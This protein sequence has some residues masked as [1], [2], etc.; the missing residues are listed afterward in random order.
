MSE[1]FLLPRVESCHRGFTIVLTTSKLLSQQV[2]V[3]AAKPAEACLWNV[4][5]NLIWNLIWDLK[6][7][8][9]KIWWN[10]GG[11]L[12]YLPGKHETFRVEFR[13]K[14]RRKFRK[15]RFKFRDFFGN[16]V[17][18]KGG[19]K[20][21]EMAAQAVTP[22]GVIS[23]CGWGGRALSWKQH[24]EVAILLERTT[25]HTLIF[26]SLPFWNSLQFYFAGN[27]LFFDCFS[28]ILQGF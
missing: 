22:V 7:P 6:F 20:V 12:F 8:M 5:W 25:N 1:G 13:G 3:R 10:F 9:G 23:W 16:F 18:Q 4:W 26:L 19:A 17:Q 2:L 21:L 24:G 27:S 11:G 28:F 14:F 15:L